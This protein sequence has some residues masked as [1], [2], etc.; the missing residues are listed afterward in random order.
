MKKFTFF[1][2][3]LLIVFT[4]HKLNAQGP[5]HLQVYKSSC[6]PGVEWSGWVNQSR[7]FFYYDFM[8]PFVTSEVTVTNVPYG[9]TYTQVYSFNSSNYCNQWTETLPLA[10]G[11]YVWNVRV[12]F[13]AGGPIGWTWSQTTWGTDFY[14]DVTPPNPPVVTDNDCGGNNSGW[15]LW[16]IHTSPYFTW[17]NPGDVGSGVSF[18]QVSVNGG[19]WTT[20]DSYWHPTYEGHVIFDFRS[21][22]YASI[23]SSPY[24]IY[25]RIDNTPPPAP[26]VNETDCL[27]HGIWTDHTSPYFI[28]TPVFDAGFP[29]DGSGI[30]R[31]EV[32]VNEGGWSSVSPP[33]HPTYGTGQYTFKFR[34]IDNVGLDSGEE[35][36]SGIYIDDTPPDPPVVTEQIAKE[37]QSKILHFLPINL[38]IS[39]GASLLMQE[40]EY[41]PTD[42]EFP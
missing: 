23:P 20:V 1:L 19:G 11:R 14:V 15:P 18:Y 12:Y 22:D 35:S 30:N 4:G 29:T 27:P 31:Y 21:V 13:N 26:S 28:W 38:Q 42:S 3:G 10:T 17:S 5:A 37:A 40:V 16:T 9:G 7:P 24:R 25:V 39:P 34:S 33:W 8:A 41:C 6:N 36:I 32:S 2:F